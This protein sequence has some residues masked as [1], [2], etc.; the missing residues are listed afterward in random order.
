LASRQ[1]NRTGATG[2]TCVAID[3][4]TTAV[5][6][7]EVEW[8]RGGDA[9]G[10]A[11]V[12]RRGS[13]P[14]PPGVWNDLET[15][16]NAISSA[17]QQALS[18]A[19]IGARRVVACLP[20]RLVTVR[21]LRL[22]PAPPEQMA[23][24]VA[25]EAQQ[26]VLFPLEEVI[27][28]HHV[29][30]LPGGKG[31]LDQDDLDTVLLAAVRRSVVAY[32]MSIFDRAGLELEQLSVSALALAELGRNSLDATAL[33][34]I[35]PG[36]I[37]VA[38]V[39]D[40]QLL[41]TRASAVDTTTADPI[42]GQRRKV[43]EVIRSFTAFQNEFRSI[44]LAHVYFGGADMGG[45]ATADLERALSEIID[46]PVKPYHGPL[47][48]ASDPT[49]SAYL[50]AIGTAL[51]TRDGSIA[52]VNLVPHERAEQRAQQSRARRNNLALLAG[53]VA[54]VAIIMSAQ[55]M[56]AKQRT[57]RKLQEMANEKLDTMNDNLTKLQKQFDTRNGLYKDLS[58]NLDRPHPS[59][60]VL[61]ALNAALPTTGDL[62][63]TQFSFERG[64]LLTL[65]GDAK[66]ATAPVNFVFALQRS[67]AFRDVR[68]SY[69]GDAQD[70][71]EDNSQSTAAAPAATTTPLPGLGAATTAQ[72]PAGAAAAPA[73]A[74]PGGAAPGGNGLRAP[75]NF[76]GPGNGPGGPGGPGFGGNGPGGQGFGGNGP[77]GP[78]GPNFG[79]NG[80]GGPGGPGFGGNGPGG[81]GFGANG[82]GGNGFR[83]GRN[84]GGANPGAN[85][86][87]APTATLTPVPSV[88]P[89]PGG[90]QRPTPAPAATAPA[91]RKPAVRAAKPTL[92][93]FIITCR[94]N[95]KARTLLPVNA[96]AVSKEGTVASNSN[97]A[98]IKTAKAN[99]NTDQGGGNNA[100]T[101]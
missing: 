63:I 1:P 74:P 57:E 54:L 29:M 8:G 53:G 43:E 32:L 47:V 83:G 96:K 7:V 51:Q 78:G 98:L 91:V 13:A 10:G 56:F 9:I 38:V 30:T 92:T 22:P 75:G 4:G 93:S 65:R 69:L 49:L 45:E 17:I 89:P 27:L 58:L 24:M 101:Q 90:I 26:Y 82:F 42:V 76:G 68:L 16:Q 99:L 3:L 67:H 41:F 39:D 84:F 81:Q 46:V 97:K 88:S 20:R 95:I 62:W 50:T 31:P 77:G 80:P 85:P 28:D 5:R 60:D 19:G 66:S 36:E 73:N 35:E 18:A 94:V 71:E 70:T 87:G 64:K 55:S 15:Y 40:G 86:T 11:R 25:F 6:A 48:P 14:L 59:V 44:Q 37:D 2:A 52:G 61:V 21:Y 100:D 23:G 79:G 34:D 12:A 33:I 72:T